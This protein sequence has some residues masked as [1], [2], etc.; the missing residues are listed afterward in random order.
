M[1]F[2]LGDEMNGK[3]YTYLHCRPD[4]TPFYVG[5]GFGN[6]A[7]N[8]SRRNPHHR[9]IIVK[10]GKENI[11]VIIFPCQSEQQALD[12]EVMKIAQLRREGYTLCNQ[13]DGGDGV[14]NPT[15]EVRAKIATGQKGKVRSAEHSAK[16]AASNT[17]KTYSAEYC[18]NMSVTQ[19][20]RYENPSER[21][22][23]SIAMKLACS[24]PVARERKSNS[25]REMWS[26]KTYREKKIAS[27]RAT[28]PKGEACPWAKVTAKDVQAIR[29]ERAS[30][31]P[32]LEVAKKYGISQP[33]VS[34]IANRKTW[35]SIP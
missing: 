28:N 31:V 15:A 7:Y 33:S 17:G 8:L 20:R 32:L 19:K 16:L 23:S 24:T 11:R 1:P 34:G 9:N 3:F 21:K 26:N 2:L 12:D 18:A 27:L 35:K 14:S 6:R 5:K 13:T 22:K 30:G 29:E 10:Y 4:G 25:S